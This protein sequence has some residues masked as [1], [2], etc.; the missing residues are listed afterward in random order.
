M[1]SQRKP[2]FIINSVAPIRICDN[3]GWTDTW[4]AGHGRIFNIGVYPYAE[5]QI[6]VYA[7][8]DSASRIVINAENYGERYV[9]NPEKHWDKHPLLEASI[10]YMHVPKDPHIFKGVIESGKSSQ[11][12]IPGRAYGLTAQATFYH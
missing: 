10:E 7:D 12:I 6:A 2:L 9:V 3:G 8:G 5:V 11:M 1:D 4:F